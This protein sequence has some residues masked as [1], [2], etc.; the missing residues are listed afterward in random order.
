MIYIFENLKII[1]KFPL[2]SFS[3]AI[4]ITEIKETVIKIMTV[5]IY[6]FVQIYSK[7]IVIVDVV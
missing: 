3:H 2:F 4:T 7:Q 6:T 1:I 5:N